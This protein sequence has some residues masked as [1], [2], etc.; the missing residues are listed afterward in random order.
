MTRVAGYTLGTTFKSTFP[1]EFVIVR[2]AIDTGYIIIRGYTKLHGVPDPYSDFG[3]EESEPL[4][5]RTDY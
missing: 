1:R 3:L 2:D 5:P 4:H